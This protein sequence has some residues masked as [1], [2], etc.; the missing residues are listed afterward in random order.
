VQKIQQKFSN[1]QSNLEF[2]TLVQV[3][4]EKIDLITVFNNIMKPILLSKK[5]ISQH[6]LVYANKSQCRNCV[7][8]GDIGCVLQMKLQATVRGLLMKMV[9]TSFLPATT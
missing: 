9:L 5:L 8:A 2:R 3:A 7:H 1:L 4:K 6:T